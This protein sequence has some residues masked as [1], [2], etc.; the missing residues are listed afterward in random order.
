MHKTR[1]CMRLGVHETRGARDQGSTRLGV[2]ETKGCTRL[3]VHE[4]RGAR[5]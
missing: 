3:G 5:Y 2:H 4:T 1:M